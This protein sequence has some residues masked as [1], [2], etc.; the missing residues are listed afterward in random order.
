MQTQY[1]V[2][3]NKF[4]TLADARSYANELNYAIAHPEEEG[5]DKDQVYAANLIIAEI[6]HYL[7]MG[8]EAL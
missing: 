6:K 5:L 1:E 2:M 7:A 4:G 3:A 8:D